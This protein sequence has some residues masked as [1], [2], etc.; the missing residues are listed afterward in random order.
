MLCVP[1]AAL[2]A[3]ANR[4]ANRT[5]YAELAS[6]RDDRPPLRSACHQEEIPFETLTPAANCTSGEPGRSPALYL[7]GDSHADHLSP[8]MQ[9]FGASSPATPTL[10]RSFPRCPPF[11]FYDKRNALDEAACHSFNAAVFAEVRALRPRGL[12]AVVLSAHWLRVFKAPRVFRISTA[13]GAENPGIAS[14]SLLSSLSETIERLMALGLRV[15]IV[16]PLPEMPYDVPDCLARRSPDQCNISRAVIDIQRRDVM[17]LL[18]DIQRRF[19]NVRIL[20]LIESV[21]DASI[22]YAEKDG[23]ILYVDGDHL[24]ASASRSML[25]AVRDT[26]LEAVSPN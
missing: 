15:V 8:L 21:C 24:S 6:A 11:A 14:P 26:L 5:Q 18:A 2:I 20:D 9:A 1:A 25:P 23:L 17:R 16:A 12:K 19:R 10:S 4:A 3:N 22:C 13:A 7:W